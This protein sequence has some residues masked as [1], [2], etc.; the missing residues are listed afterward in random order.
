[1][2]VLVETQGHLLDNIEV[3]RGEVCT[4]RYTIGVHVG[5]YTKRTMVGATEG[6]L[7]CLHT[8]TSCTLTQAQV[9]RS[10]EYVEAG[11]RELQKAKKYQKSGRKIMCAVFILFLV[12]ALGIALGIT[13]PMLR[14][15]KQ[16]GSTP[17]G[18]PPPPA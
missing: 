17:A 13:I 18:P 8:L 16:G 14:K 11:T 4:G 12:I 7:L 3:C 1:M 5:R 2:A 6:L 15:N 10:A 9:Q